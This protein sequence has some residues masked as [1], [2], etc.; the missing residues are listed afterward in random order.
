M[1]TADNDQR[2]DVVYQVGPGRN[3][4]RKFSVAFLKH[5]SALLFSGRPIR[6]WVADPATATVI[7]FLA[8][9]LSKAPSIDEVGD[10]STLYYRIFTAAA[11]IRGS[12][13]AQVDAIASA[14]QLAIKM[15]RPRRT[16][17]PHRV[18]R[19]HPQHLGARTPER[20]V[21]AP[22]IATRPVPDYL[23]QLYYRSSTLSNPNSYRGG[24]IRS[25]PMGGQ[26][27]TR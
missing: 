4:S 7:A 5:L 16:G 14:L 20:P 2:I 10:E 11:T 15:Y 25:I 24:R 6:E 26:P 1:M 13:L 18:H 3:A 17:R 21:P 27:H 23:R 9:L 19:Q 8:Q 12:R 22:P